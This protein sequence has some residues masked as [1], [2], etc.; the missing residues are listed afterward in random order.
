MQN[1]AGERERESGGGGVGLAQGHPPYSLQDSN[2]P[3]P[4]YKPSLSRP[5][6]HSFV[7]LVIGRATLQPCCSDQQQHTSP[8]IVANMYHLHCYPDKREKRC[9]CSK[10]S[11]LFTCWL[12]ASASCRRPSVPLH[13]HH[14]RQR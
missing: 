5:L 13:L 12:S 6:L 10:N 8:I 1:S 7:F 9:S 14:Q 4:S 11:A 3:V 2:Y